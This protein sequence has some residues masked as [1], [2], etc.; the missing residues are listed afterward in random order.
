MNTNAH[1]HK[2]HANTNKY[3]RSRSKQLRS[4]TLIKSANHNK[5][6]PKLQPNTQDHKLGPKPAKFVTVRPKPRP[7]P[8]KPIPGTYHK[9]S[10]TNIYKYQMLSS[11][12]G[13]TNYINQS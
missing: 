3:L 2:K 8:L 5:K 11:D 9:Q 12:L 13:N 10:K 4:K 7:K 6:L 1:T